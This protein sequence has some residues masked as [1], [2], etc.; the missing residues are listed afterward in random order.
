MRTC[1]V[2]KAALW[3]N[4]AVNLSK[5]RA[6]GAD[7]GCRDA[8]ASCLVSAWCCL[9]QTLP[10]SQTCGSEHCS[11]LPAQAMSIHHHTLQKQAAAAAQLQLLHAAVILRFIPALDHS[12]FLWQPGLG[13]RTLPSASRLENSAAPF[14][15]GEY[16]GK[17]TMK[18]VQR[19]G[20]MKLQASEHG[21]MKAKM[22]EN[23]AGP[24]SSVGWSSNH[25]I[26]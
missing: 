2:P 26:K 1:W 15:S 4:D 5:E 22:K 21:E 12:K 25:R 9:V 23:L 7:R 16:H 13:S 20:K 24:C 19:G 3:Q 18:A 10:P 17:Q 11:L 8:R 14:A 6:T